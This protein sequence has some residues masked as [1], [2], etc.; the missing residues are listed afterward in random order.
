MC[1]SARLFQCALCSRQALICSHCD[2][3]HQYCSQ[4]CARQARRQSHNRANQKYSQTLRGK[5]ANAARQKRYRQRQQQKVT[6]QGSPAKRGAVSLPLPVIP[7][8]L[9]SLLPLVKGAWCAICHFCH[10]SI[11]PLLRHDFL[12]RLSVYR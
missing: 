2:R 7:A 6:D 8:V 1:T 10:R 4:A 11:S 12:H 3:G 5:H 9:G